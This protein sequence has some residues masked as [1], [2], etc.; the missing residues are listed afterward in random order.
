[1]EKIA[2]EL[3]TICPDAPIIL[4][5]SKIDL[6]GTTKCI[7]AERGEEW[8]QKLRLWHYAECSAAADLNVRGVF[9]EAVRA[10]VPLFS[11]TDSGPLSH[12]HRPLLLTDTHATAPPAAVPAPQQQQ[13]KASSPRRLTTMRPPS[14]PAPERPLPMVP[15]PAAPAEPLYVAQY[16]YL[17]DQREG[18]LHFA[19]FAVI[20]LV[21][22]GDDGWWLG[23]LPNGQT[24][25]FPG[26]YVLPV[27]TS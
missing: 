15:P 20:T 12:A 21:E 18:V 24:G 19:R 8:C 11:L 26:S 23:K 17:D 5:G 4:V 9:E 22:K 2:N 7:S 10:A 3:R 1:V 13:P 25:Y 6:R 27:T 14:R 16:D